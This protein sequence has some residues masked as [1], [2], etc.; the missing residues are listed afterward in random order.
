MRRRMV[1]V[2]EHPLVLCLHF[3][4]L[5]THSSDCLYVSLSPNQ[6]RHFSRPSAYCPSFTFLST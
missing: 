4:I 1:E 6:D 2:V 5:G 3:F